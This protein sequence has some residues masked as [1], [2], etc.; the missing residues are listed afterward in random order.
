MLKLT[1]LGIAAIVAL[2]LASAIVTTVNAP[3]YEAPP[4]TGPLGEAAGP[5][6]GQNTVGRLVLSFEPATRL[7]DRN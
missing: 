7:I 4:A 1:A 3:A 6:T 2:G 5:R